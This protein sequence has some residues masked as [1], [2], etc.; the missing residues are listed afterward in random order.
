MLAATVLALTGFS[1]GHGHGHSGH[2]GSGGGCSSS[3][4]DHDSTT[5][6]TS[7]GR[8]AYDD[9]DDTYGDADAEDSYGTG[10]SSSGGSSSRRPG[11]RSTPSASGTASGGDLAAGKVR[12]VS[13]ATQKAPYATVEVSNPNGAGAKFTAFVEFRDA[14][15]ESVAY[16]SAEVTVPA[17]GTARV[18]V[19]LDDGGVKDDGLIHEVDHCAPDPTAPPL[20]D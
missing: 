3:H 20:D 15:D 19:P 11:Y 7:G 12:L 5:S 4:Q 1:R 14:E 9:T 6:S 17:D 18:R 16:R 13:C 10:G 8:S 2:G